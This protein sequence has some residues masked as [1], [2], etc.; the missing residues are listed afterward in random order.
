MAVNKSDNLK[1]SK[2][3]HMQLGSVNYSCEGELCKILEKNLRN[4]L[5]QSSKKNNN[6]Y[7]HSY[8]V[9]TTLNLES[10]GHRKSSCSST[11][12]TAIKE[13]L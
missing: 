6:T 11:V 4:F 8:L 3:N 5:K 9:T 10:Q 7:T 13:H 12:E 1:Y 2:K